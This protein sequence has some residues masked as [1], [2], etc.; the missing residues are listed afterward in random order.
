MT[1]GLKRLSAPD[2]SLCLLVFFS[3]TLK[4]TFVETVSSTK[5]NFFLICP[6]VLVIC[7]GA[8]LEKS[9]VIPCLKR[10]FT[11]FFEFTFCGEYIIV[12]A[13]VTEYFCFANFKGHYLLFLP[14]CF[15]NI[16]GQGENGP[17]AL[18]FGNPSSWQFS[19]LYQ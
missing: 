2:A 5:K 16:V 3:N 15:E 8:L 14:S 19:D 10:Y 9:L 6:L 7:K 18:A 11:N 12:E 1:F 13:G 17:P 4:F